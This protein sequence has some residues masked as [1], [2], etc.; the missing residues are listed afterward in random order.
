MSKAAIQSMLQRF[1]EAGLEVFECIQLLMYATGNSSFTS[2]GNLYRIGISGLNEPPPLQVLL[3][4]DRKSVEEVIVD[5]DDL[6]PLLEKVEELLLPVENPVYY[7]NSRLIFSSR[8]LEGFIRAPGLFTMYPVGQWADIRSSGWARGCEG[9]SN[10]LSQNDG[11]GPPF[12]LHIEVA[13]DVP[14]DHPL[15][16]ERYLS[17][18]RDAECLAALL[19]RGIT[20][21][22]FL[23]ST[24]QWNTGWDAVT[25]EPFNYLASNGF[26]TN[27]A[28]SFE[29]FVATG[30][31]EAP[32]YSGEAEYTDALIFDEAQTIPP[33]LNSA[34]DKFLALNRT[35]KKAFLRACYLFGAAEAVKGQVESTPLYVSAIECVLDPIVPNRCSNC[36][37]EQHSISRR[38]RDFM[39]RYA[40]VSERLK[41]ERKSMYAKRSNIVHGRFVSAVDDPSWFP[42]L[43]TDEILFPWLTRKALVNWLLST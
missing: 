16:I 7:N 28:T 20:P 17:K 22:S 2:S 37:Q 43:E 6:Q 39:D 33:F 8:K 5:P 3:S 36:G 24:R 1:S 15:F 40:H 25:G 27:V 14:S 35:R 12:P 32:T 29:L 26:S 38:F 9:T 4:A 23:K 18:I 31:S 11:A 19:I 10:G 41:N 42:S 13:V 30:G 21:V 34:V